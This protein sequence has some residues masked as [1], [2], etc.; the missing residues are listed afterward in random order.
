M[1]ADLAAA[2]T[3]RGAAGGQSSAAPTFAFFAGMAET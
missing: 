2:M 3:G 1:P